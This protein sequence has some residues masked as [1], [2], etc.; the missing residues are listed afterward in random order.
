M[1]QRIYVVSNSILNTIYASEIKPGKARLRNISGTLISSIE[2]RA[3]L[4]ADEAKLK[5]YMGTIIQ[6]VTGLS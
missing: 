2:V 6:S 5:R 4:R 1:A 3:R